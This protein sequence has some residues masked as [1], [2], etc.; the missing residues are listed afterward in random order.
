MRSGSAVGSVVLL[1]DALLSDVLLSEALTLLKAV[2]V[3]L[4]R[5]VAPIS[6]VDDA[7]CAAGAMA[8]AAAPSSASNTVRAARRVAPPR[9]DDRRGKL[10]VGVVTGS[11]FRR[12]PGAC[13]LASPYTGRFA[14]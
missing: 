8:S 13:Q 6:V 4:T 2:L 7:A 11:H 10:R 12:D 3:P 9:R 5:A 1:S 14:R